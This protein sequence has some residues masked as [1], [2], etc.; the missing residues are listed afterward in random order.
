MY[1]RRWQKATSTSSW[2]EG[3]QDGRGKDHRSTP[4]EV[5]ADPQSVGSALD[6][7][8]HREGLVLAEAFESRGLRC[9]SE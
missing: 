3:E 9:L 8:T 5:A 7:S 6:G 1:E 2:E 4:P